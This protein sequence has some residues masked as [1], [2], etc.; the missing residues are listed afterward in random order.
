MTSIQKSYSNLLFDTVADLRLAS[1]LVGESCRTLGYYSAGDGGGAEYTIVGAGTGADDGGSFLDLANGNQ[2]QLIVDGVVNAKTFGTLGDGSIELTTIQ[3]IEAFAFSNNLDVFFPPG[4]Y[5]VGNANWPFRNSV[6]SPLKDYG[7]IKI[8]GVRGQTIFRTTSNDGA[9]VLQLNAVQGIAFKDISVTAIL[10]DTIGSGSN[11]A[12]ITNGGQD[13]DL[14]IDIFNMPGVDAGAFVDGGKGFTIQTG[15]GGNGFKNISIRGKVTDSVFGFGFDTPFEE[16]NTTVGPIPPSG[17][18][19]NIVAEDCWQGVALGAATPQVAGTE[20]DLDCEVNVNATVI[21][22]AQ[23][24]TTARWVRGNINIHINNT[25]D[26][27]SLFRPKAT[28]QRVFGAEI[29]NYFG[30]NVRISGRMEETDNKLIIGA[31]NTQLGFSGA[32]Q[33]CDIRFEMTAGTTTGDEVDVINVGGNT[34]ENCII[35]LVNITDATGT[36]LIRDDN[37]VVFDAAYQIGTATINNLV[38]PRTGQVYNAFEADVSSNSI[39]IIRVGSGSPGAPDGFATIV[40]TISST[41]Y[42]I[43]LYT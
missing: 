26:I 34:T 29:L 18:N 10:T 1:L 31:A 43:Q 37:R 38:V 22:C 13:I 16:F 9:D 36:D 11:G 30:G 39:G 23:P 2:A 5:D 20:E 28:D 4:T 15:T 33:E 41:T 17:I 3:N 40:D 8:S 19:V 6:N 32:C 42:K 7:G 21:N 25:K 12:S 14:D 35:T 24:F 27:A